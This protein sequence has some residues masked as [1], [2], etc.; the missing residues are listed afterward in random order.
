MI[1]SGEELNR[2]LSIG[3]KE[4]ASF[5]L[6]TLDV[7]QGVRKARFDFDYSR[8]SMPEPKIDCSF[9]QLYRY[10]QPDSVYPPRS[11]EP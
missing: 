8:E 6:K 11:G 4:R 7:A 9:S 5:K 10:C 1:T 2:K 3:R